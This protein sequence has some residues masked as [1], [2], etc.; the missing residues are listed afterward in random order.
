MAG[1]A[2]RHE[3]TL[4]G[5]LA[6]LQAT[7]APTV[8]VEVSPEAATSPAGQHTAWMLINLLARQESV[9]GRVVLV[10][11]PDMRLR[12][13]IVPLAPRYLDLASALVEGAR[14][15]EAVPV[16]VALRPPA[17]AQRLIVGTGPA[18]P[19]ALLVWGERAW[20][21][22]SAG[23]ITSAD[24]ESA[25]PLGPYAAACLASAHV[26]NTVRMRDGR[27]ALPE[28]AF[29]SLWSL[30]ASSA[31][32]TAP[33]DTGPYDISTA[34]DVIVAGAGAVGSAWIHAMWATPGLRGRAVIADAD[35]EGVDLSNLN[36]CVTF[37]RASIGRRKALEAARICADA[38]VSLEP[39]DGPV[40]DVEDRPPLLVSAVDTNTS[41]QA[42][43]GMY[44]PQIISASTDG[45]RAEL[46]RCDPLA[47]A[48]CIHCFNPP[49]TDVSDDALRRRFL[50]AGSERQEQL[51]VESGQSVEELLRWA[52]E[53]T[54][55]YAS[56][57]L[58]QHMRATDQRAGAFAVG[59]AS[60]MAGTMLAAQTLKEG[61]GLGPLAGARCRAIFTFVDPL[62]TT[63]TPRL[64]RRD[65][66]CPMCAPGSPGRVIW[67]GRHREYADS[68]RVC[69]E[70]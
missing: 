41:R 51:A 16:E 62:A 68:P 48:A 2:N 28:A 40:G 3:G 24:A 29:Y 6:P 56:D 22:I 8:A 35:E 39:H 59:F 19:G 44:P 5:L 47:D 14:A 65:D 1:L 26:F 23:A 10:C 58:M 15:V 17:G 67:A 38:D 42:V 61:L 18:I 36:R 64:Y 31:P 7:S 9:I 34:L 54:C 13:R 52:T 70:T 53:G 11:P 33:S 37:G 63:N 12:G 25:L 60:V 21:G 50:A 32:P 66:S 46:L 55:G 20:G 4:D 27:T 30:T 43:Q 69:S 49:E 57:R 45:M